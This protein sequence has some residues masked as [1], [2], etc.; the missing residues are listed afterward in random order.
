MVQHTLKSCNKLVEREADS[1]TNLAQFE[2]VKAGLLKRL[3]DWIAVR[4]GFAGWSLEDHRL[5]DGIAAD[6]L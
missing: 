4:P 1:I 3:G 5:L 2:N 6:S